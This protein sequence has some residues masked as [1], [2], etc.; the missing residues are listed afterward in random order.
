MTAHD[1]ILVNHKYISID[2]LSLQMQNE[3]QKMA[4][5]K[6]IGCCHWDLGEINGN[7]W[8]ICLGWESGYESDKSDPFSYDEMHLAMKLAYQPQNSIMQ[9]DYDIDWLMPYDPETSAVDDNEET[10]YHDTDFTDI[11]I[12]YIKLHKQ[13]TESLS[14]V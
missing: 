7:T 1:M 10:V 5:N 2:T 12:R 4:E 14:T 13:Y 3:A 6:L 11:A 8:A 9:C